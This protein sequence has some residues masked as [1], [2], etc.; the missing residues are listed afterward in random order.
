MRRRQRNLC[1]SHYSTC[2]TQNN[3]FIIWMK[4]KCTQ[5]TSIHVD[6]L[7]FFLNKK[8]CFMAFIAFSETGVQDEYEMYGF[9]RN[10]GYE[11]E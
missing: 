7:I 3:A 4:K 1:I 6:E 9:I 5:Y 8:K 11:Q 10:N 2:V